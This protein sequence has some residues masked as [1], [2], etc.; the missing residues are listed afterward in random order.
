MLQMITDLLILTLQGSR[1]VEASISVVIPKG[2]K[3]GL[4]LTLEN[5]GHENFEGQ[6]G[7]V[8]ATVKYIIPQDWLVSEDISELLHTKLISLDFFLGTPF[9]ELSTPLG[10][11]V[12][13]SMPKLD[14]Q[15]SHLLFGFNVTI[16]HHGMLRGEAA[17]AVL[18]S[19]G[20]DEVDLDLLSADDHRGAGAGADAGVEG[21]HR[22]TQD[23]ESQA[24]R[25]DLIVHCDLDWKSITESAFQALLAVTIFGLTSSEFT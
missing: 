11:T 5:A 19:D 13:V 25:G 18:D 23:E 1:M 6:K 10:E 17:A 3:N 4:Q 12:I 8:I 7:K 21:L 24:A 20:V 2:F 15:L 9:F 16:K 22:K 14:V